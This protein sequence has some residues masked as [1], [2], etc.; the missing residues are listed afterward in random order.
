MARISCKVG[1]NF[2]TIVKNLATWDYLLQ[3][4]P[5]KYQ[6]YRICQCV[7][8]FEVKG[9][10]YHHFSLWLNIG[11]WENAIFNAAQKV[12]KVI[13]FDIYQDFLVVHQLCL[14]FL[15]CFHRKKRSVEFLFVTLFSLL[16]FLPPLCQC[17]NI[18]KIL[19]FFHRVSTKMFARFYTSM[20]LSVKFT[21][22]VLPS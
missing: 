20:W 4:P 14:Y 5:R 22:D 15:W 12:T 7:S 13:W 2:R 9:P 1:Q 16:F 11:L 6:S 21:S 18:F 19:P 17:N 3:S 10:L 8:H